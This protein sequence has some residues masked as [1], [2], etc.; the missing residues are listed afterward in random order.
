M[1]D[2]IKEMKQQMEHVHNDLSI[3]RETVKHEKEE[4]SKT[5]VFYLLDVN[6]R[7]LSQQ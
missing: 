3:L 6:L 5:I 1:N 4:V 2:I 7:G